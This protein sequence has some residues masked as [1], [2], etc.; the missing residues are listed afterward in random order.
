MIQDSGHG[1]WDTEPEQ[2][3]G[4]CDHCWG[5]HTVPWRECDPAD[6][7]DSSYKVDDEGGGDGKD[8]AGKAD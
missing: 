7:K 8:D 3:V 1:W 6:C 4:S 2:P 5:Y